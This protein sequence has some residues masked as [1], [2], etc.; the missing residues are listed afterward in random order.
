MLVE[1]W[2]EGSTIVEYDDLF[3]SSESPRE[4][5]IIFVIVSLL[6]QVITSTGY[7]KYQI[8]PWVRKTNGAI[9]SPRLNPPLSPSSPLSKKA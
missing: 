2:K 6:V 9:D 7:V 4:N 8:R 1:T 5:I 3:A